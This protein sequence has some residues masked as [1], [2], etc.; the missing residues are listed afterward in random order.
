MTFAEV[1]TT[2]FNALFRYHRETTYFYFHGV[3]FSN[4]I[5]P[6]GVNSMIA[7]KTYKTHPSHR[8]LDGPRCPLCVSLF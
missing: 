1:G 7:K 4:R 8:P 2:V 6:C 3:I 5:F